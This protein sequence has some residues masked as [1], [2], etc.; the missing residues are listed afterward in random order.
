MIT[1]IIVAAGKGE[2]AGFAENKILKE[3]NGLSALSYSLSACSEADEMIVVCREED[4]ERIKKLLSPFSNAKI[5]RGGATRAESVYRG[6]KAANGE[7]VLVHD[8]ARPFISR[9]TV[10]DC[11]ACVK[12]Y[13]SGVCALPSTDTV[14]YAE[15]GNI[16][17]V[18]PRANVYTVQTPQGF[19]REKL[20]QSYE[21]ALRDGAERFTDESGIY[22]AYV[23]PPRLFLGERENKKLTYPEDFKPAERV[24]FGVDTHAFYAEDEGAPFVNFITLAGVRIPSDKIL[25]AH[26]DGDVLIH[27]LMDALF[28]AAGLRDIGYHFPDTDPQYKNA[29]SMKLL[30]E[31]LSRVKDAGFSPKNVSLSILAETPRLSPHIDRMKE[32]LSDALGLPPNAVGIA[33]G[34][35]EKLGYIGQKKGITVYACVLCSKQ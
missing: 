35:N 26:S 29:D 1:A 24:G 12:E 20:L 3:L 16:V 2:R 34:T 27:A 13:G 25:K 8:A 30:S 32:N 21:C 22:L 11:V 7:I 28:S 17:S 6:L 10:S 23:E 31:A 15:N 18:P 5:C 14:V 9:K 19:Y 4:E 33:A